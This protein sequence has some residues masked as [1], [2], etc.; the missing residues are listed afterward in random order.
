MVHP[1][2]A[3]FRVDYHAMVLVV[4][5]V[6]RADGQVIV[7]T[8]AHQCLG[9]GTNGGERPSKPRRRDC[10]GD[11]RVLTHESLGS[12]LFAFLTTVRELRLVPREK[13]LLSRGKKEEA[14]AHQ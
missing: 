4:T 13:E 7:N 6:K 5:R 8:S 1:S 11:V 2:K 3:E 12:L 10:G 9:S 14:A